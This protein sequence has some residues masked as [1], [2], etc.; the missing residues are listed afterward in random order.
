[1]STTKKKEK[2]YSIGEAARIANTTSE[3]LRHYDRIALVKPSWKDE[4]TNY[5]YYTDQDIVRINTVRALQLMDL[6]LKE[7][8]RVL[9]YDSLE[10]I[11]EFLDQAEKK[12]KEKIAVLQYSR[13]KIKAA[14]EDYE[15][16]L[17]WKETERGIL[18][19]SYPER[20]IL[21]SDTLKEP[22]LDNLWNYLGSFY[23]QLPPEKRDTFSFE[24]LAGIYTDN[25]KS[26]LFA[27]CTRHESVEGLK[28]LPEGKYL[29]LDCREE[30]RENAI[31]KLESTAINEYGIKPAFILQLII[32]SGILHWDYQIQVHIGK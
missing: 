31:R 16:K 2:Y 5:R 28:V 1:M 27:L 14:K 23:A 19:K 11:I 32:L 25:E 26:G 6:P 4:W 29:S 30:E 18:V 22:S 15:S 10:E 7:I 20:V 3:T 21:L 9:E 17:R 8:R 24:D 12:A 13:K